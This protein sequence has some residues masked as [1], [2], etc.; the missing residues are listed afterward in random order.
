M[1]CRPHLQCLFIP[2]QQLQLKH[3][4]DRSLVLHPIISVKIH[5]LRM[6]KQSCGL[7]SK[8]WDLGSKDEFHYKLW[9]RTTLDKSLY[10]P[11]R[12]HLYSIIIPFVFFVKR[13]FEDSW[14]N[15]EYKS[16]S[17]ITLL[18]LHLS[19]KPSTQLHIKKYSTKHLYVNKSQRISPR[20]DL[21][22]L[23]PSTLCIRILSKNLQDLQIQAGAHQ[24]NILFTFQ[25]TQKTHSCFA[26]WML[27][28]P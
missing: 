25:N 18:Q 20:R 22:L 24:H 10:G 13:C 19:W 4:W 27:Y 9:N 5:T 2:S 17:I 26:L 23:Y 15:T 12:F 28:M 6:Q 3:S 11:K 1:G 7:P 8:T 21:S 14:Q 16:K